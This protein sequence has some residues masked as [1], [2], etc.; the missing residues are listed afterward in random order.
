MGSAA[1][2]VRGGGARMTAHE[3]WVH[4]RIRGYRITK[5]YRISDQ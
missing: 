3:Q 1:Y 2:K 5:G 4:F